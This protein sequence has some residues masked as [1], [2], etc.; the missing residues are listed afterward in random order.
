MGVTI[1]Q[2]RARI[3]SHNNVIV[4]Q[5]S[6]PLEDIN[7]CGTMLMLFQLVI[8]IMVFTNIGA[9][10]LP[11]CIFIFANKEVGRTI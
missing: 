2:Y 11:R 3:G 5:D 8:T 4:K 10:I 9:N 6:T 1:D 7:F